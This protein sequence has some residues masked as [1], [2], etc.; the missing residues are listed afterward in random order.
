MPHKPEG[1]LV[2]AAGPLYGPDVWSVEVAGWCHW[3]PGTRFRVERTGGC[4][5]ILQPNFSAPLST[6]WNIRLLTGP[7]DLEPRDIL[8]RLE[9]APP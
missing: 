1:A 3:H 8:L 6:R 4:W 5:L 7:E 2:L 9:P